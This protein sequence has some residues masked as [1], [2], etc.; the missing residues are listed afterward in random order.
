MIRESYKTRQNQ[1]SAKVVL[2]S[3][4]Y[5]HLQ[6]SFS[7]FIPG[8]L[9]VLRTLETSAWVYTNGGAALHAEIMDVVLGMLGPGSNL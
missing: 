3:V 6:K 8:M 7:V 5:N 4:A 2:V 9:E 1:Q